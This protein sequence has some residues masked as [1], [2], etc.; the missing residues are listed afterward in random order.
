MFDLFDRRRVLFVR[1]PLHS[2]LVVQTSK[3]DQS[4]PRVHYEH[5]YQQRRVLADWNHDAEQSTPN[6]Q[7]LQEQKRWRPSSVDVLHRLV[8]GHQHGP[9]L[10]PL[11][12]RFQP[13]RRDLHVVSAKH[14]AHLHD[15]RVQQRDLL[16]DQRTRRR[17]YLRIYDLLQLRDV[18]PW[19]RLEVPNQLCRHFEREFKNT[20]NYFELQ[21][22]VDRA[23]VFSNLIYKL[24]P[25]FM[26]TYHDNPDDAEPICYRKHPAV[27]DRVLYLLRSNHILQLRQEA[28]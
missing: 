3:V 4:Q 17:V 16:M 19:L 15:Q 28:V 12:A 6:H 11:G 5:A 8:H 10:S 1:L 2:E 9:I 13:V 20:A 21:N 24:L 18:P 7:D 27:G 23:T 26:T 14:R 22:E 25:E